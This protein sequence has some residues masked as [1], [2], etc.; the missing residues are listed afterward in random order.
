[1]AWELNDQE[2]EAV[3][4]LPATERYDYF[5]KRAAGRGPLWGLRTEGGWVVAEDD[6]GCQHVPV[7]PHQRWAQA[8]AHGPW[9]GAEPVVIDV[10]EWVGR[11]CRILAAIACASPSSRPST[12]TVSE[13][14]RSA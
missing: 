13:C 2:F 10:D 1:M 12:I 7:W 6:E 3:G 4:G 5:L 9:S 11:G 8:L 14:H